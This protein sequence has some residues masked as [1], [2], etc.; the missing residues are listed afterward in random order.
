M[1]PL[2]TTRP[3]LTSTVSLWARRTGKD[4]YSLPES[5]WIWIA[6]E[7][8]REAAALKEHRKAREERTLARIPAAKHGGKGAGRRRALAIQGG[9][10]CSAAGSMPWLYLFLLSWLTAIFRATFCIFRSP[11]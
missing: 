2:A 6:R 5:S 8:S 7:L 3:L 1:E 4:L 9:R 11:F 10:L